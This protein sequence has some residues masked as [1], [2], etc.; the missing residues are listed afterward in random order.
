MNTNDDFEN[1]R[2]IEEIENLENDSTEGAIKGSPI[3]QNKKIDLENIVFIFVIIV[4]VIAGIYVYFKNP[5]ATEEMFEEYS[6]EAIGNDVSVEDISLIPTDSFSFFD[7]SEEYEENL[8]YEEYENLIKQK[9]DDFHR[10]KENLVVTEKI[11]DVNKNLIA[12][13]ENKNDVSLIDME[14]YAVFFDGENNI[15][16]VTSDYLDAIDA[17]SKYY[18]K[19]AYTPE[20]YEKCEIFIT[21]RYFDDEEYIKL[22]NDKITFT[23][24][25]DKD[26]QIEIKATNNAN[27]M[28]DYINFS[29]VYYDENDKI[30][31]V[32]TTSIL[33]LKKNKSDV[34]TVY[35][36]WDIEKEEYI[37]YDHYEVILNYAYTYTD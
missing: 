12:C 29:V 24:S 21:K 23:D 27:G 22:Y 14:I 6:K 8:S 35:G 15:I 36:G 1:K 10:Q 28:I 18:F 4:V 11:L 33:E 2:L 3:K 34:T 37:N 20:N 30:L 31:Y 17:N 7:F 16:E 5:K 13:I 19:V 32:D 26:R 25:I 9:E